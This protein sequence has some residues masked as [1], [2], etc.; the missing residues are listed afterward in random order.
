MQNSG[1]YITH[2]LALAL[3]LVTGAWAQMRIISYEVPG[4]AQGAT[5]A[6]LAYSSA[7]DA[8]FALVNSGVETST[9]G[10]TAKLW[11]SD[12]RVYPYYG[13]QELDDF[14]PVDMA[15]SPRINQFPAMG[16]NLM[17][18]IS[19]RFLRLCWELN[20]SV[21]FNMT[22]GEHILNATAPKVNSKI[23]D[24]SYF[25]FSSQTVLN[26]VGVDP[27]GVFWVCSSSGILRF[28]GEDWSIVGGPAN[29]VAVD[30]SGL[31]YF[32]T[33][34][35]GVTT[36]RTT[37]FNTLIQPERIHGEVSAI[38]V[39]P[40]GK[41]LWFAAWSAVDNKVGLY[42]YAGGNLT[43]TLF[44]A[45][46]DG[47]SRVPSLA[48]DTEGTLWVATVS[49]VK[50]LRN[51][52]WT[53]YSTSDGLTP[54]KVND[55]LAISPN[56]VWCATD[57]G[58][59]LFYTPGSYDLYSL[60]RESVI[61]SSAVIDSAGIAYFGRVDGMFYAVQA[62]KDG[63]I[64]NFQQ[65][66][67]LWSFQTGG[68]VLSSAGVDY[69]GTIYVG[70]NDHNLYALHPNGK[71]KWSYTTG[72]E[73]VS[74]PAVGPEGGV[75][76]GSADGFIYA[77]DQSGAL[78]WRF[79][80]SGQVLASPAL[81]VDGTV[82]CGSSDGRMYALDSR[83]RRR[84]S[85]QTSGAI[86]S[87]AA[88][89][90]EGRLYFGSNDGNLY[91]L[92]PD[93]ALI[94]R[95][96]TGGPVIASPCL[97]PAK[98]L[99]Y[100][101]SSDSTLCALNMADGSLAWTFDVEAPVWSSA[102]ICTNGDVI[103]HSSNLVYVDLDIPRE[104]WPLPYSNYRLDGVTGAVRSS[105]RINLGTSSTSCVSVDGP[106]WCVSL[107]G[108]NGE[109]S[110]QFI[111][112][113]DHTGWPK[114]RH[115]FR[116]TGNL[117]TSLEI[118]MKSID[119][120][121]IDTRCDL[122]RDGSLDIKDVLFLM[123]GGI[124]EPDNPVVDWDGDGRWSISDAS[125]LLRDLLSGKCNPP[126]AILSAGNVFAPASHA[127]NLGQM[128]LIQLETALDQMDLSQDQ[129]EQ[130]L[131]ELYAL[132]SHATLPR[133]FLLMQNSPNPFNPST[134]IKFEVPDGVKDNISLCVFDLRGRKV[135]TLIDGQV[136]PGIHVVFWEGTDQ[137]GR[138]L[139]SGVYFYRLNAG[140]FERVRKMVMLK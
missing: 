128:D 104:H 97:D 81:G 73:V 114:W 105:T 67:I 139:P 1:R 122:C 24:I 6:G 27:D 72:G 68:P 33:P 26:C 125:L 134:A 92:G 138:K 64:N 50:V 16:G 121:A 130:F 119:Q 93:G 131:T 96:T 47:W 70:S 5:V 108:S 83:G 103:C 10:L 100:F 78:L 57:R 28:A 49:G 76:F 94:W 101:G 66:A 53:T 87:S 136:D 62:L 18:A 48:V 30:G 71:L 59:S 44:S 117:A 95:R 32:G 21:R 127:Y 8:K 111:P 46:V 129:H 124:A 99:V 23:F 84:W 106:A 63:E 51:G 126:Q 118:P 133:A 12:W 79:Q 29:C 132:A 19:Q 86:W 2:A 75:Y 54:G 43:E 74:S 3:L 60:P 107:D 52:A 89:D 41:I 25:G 7:N 40:D 13:P 88:I 42:R 110:Q 58:I 137:A 80:T 65:P 35:H 14:A 15:V 56:K 9:R 4:V 77:L 112:G 20:E 116:N 37:A 55:I 90:L 85:Y 39:S 109:D 135:A 61:S 22:S 120:Y 36:C 31:K 98:G 45:G 38:D 113:Y 115:D 91:V 102:V 17:L 11:S 82:Y 69:V 34:T 123:A 140:D